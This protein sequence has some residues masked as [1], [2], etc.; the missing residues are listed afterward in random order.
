[1]L[2]LQFAAL[3]WNCVLVDVAPP[4]PNIGVSPVADV[5]S[6][7]IGIIAA[8]TNMSEGT[9]RPPEP[10]LLDV[11]F[12][13]AAEPFLP[14][15]EGSAYD[16]TVCMNPFLTQVGDEWRLYYAGA[17]S[18]SVHRIALATAPVAPGSTTPGVGAKWTRKGVV[19]N[20][21]EA[22]SFNSLWS[23]L[24]LVHKF[25]NVWHM[26]VGNRNRPYRNPSCRESARG[27]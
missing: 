14:P 18:S 7:T 23:V 27:H 12:R 2:G 4:P 25:G 3:V 6:K 11:Q 16:S 21:G 9:Q 13:N 15:V 26:Y 5:S 1:M 20:N 22:G 10:K 17:D 19:L 8:G 24:P